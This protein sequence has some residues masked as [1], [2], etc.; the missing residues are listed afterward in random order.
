MI[1]KTTNTTTKTG[2]TKT[3]RTSKPKKNDSI[4]IDTPKN[5]KTVDLNTILTIRDDFKC[6]TKTQKDLVM[7]INGKEIIISAGSAGVGKSY[8]SIA[9]GLELL[10][11]D[12]NKF[13]K[14]IISTPIVEADEK[15]GFLPGDIREKMDP[16][17]SSSLD[18]FD[19]LIGKANRVKL[20][21][22]GVLEVQALAYIRGKSIDNTILIMEE[23]QNMSPAQMKTLLTRIGENSKFIISGDLDQS[24]RYRDYTKS[25][26]Y[27]AINRHKNISEIGFI[28]FSDEDIVRNPIIKKIINNYPRLNNIDTN[29]TKAKQTLLVENTNNDKKNDNNGLFSNLFK[30]NK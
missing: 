27:D 23:A 25:G 24:D 6:K 15:L 19:K 10:R 21:E 30:K 1:K 26:L 3:T 17:L 16:Y 9:R 12:N 20:E 28:T 22:L 29:I 8:V 13:T 14:M 11:N 5:K 18:I 7:A 4:L 2:T